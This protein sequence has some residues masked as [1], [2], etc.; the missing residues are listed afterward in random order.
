[1]GGVA[2]F[3]LGIWATRWVVAIAPHNLPRLDQTRVDAPWVLFAFA[4]S[5]ATA[6]LFGVLPVM[7][8]SRLQGDAMRPT[9]RSRHGRSAQLGSRLLVGSQVAMTVLLLVTSGL[10]LRSLWGLEKV[11]TGIRPENTLAIGVSLPERS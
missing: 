5:T 8:R 6:I 2:G 10:F 9:A 1:M 11:D 4:L 3:V 7:R